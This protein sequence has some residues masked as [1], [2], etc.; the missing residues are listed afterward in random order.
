MDQI[1]ALVITALPEEFEAARLAAGDDVRWQEREAGSSAPYIRGELATAAGGSLAVALARP[2]AMSGRTT[3]PITT[4]LAA[5][6]RPACL[7]MCGVCAGNPADTAPGDVLVAAPAFQYDEGKLR[8]DE[9]LGDL[10]QLPLEDRWLR[11][12]QDFDP[13]GLPSQGPATADEAVVW[14]LERLLLGQEPR[15]HP[16][17]SRYFPR[18]TWAPRLADLEAA[19]LIARAENGTVVLTD[20]GR[21]RI[22]RVRY[23]TVDGPE[24]LP[25]AVFAG[26]MGSGNAVV[27]DPGVWDRLRHMGT[28]K[29]LGLEMEAATVATVAEHSEVPHWLVAKGVMDGAE[30]VRED[31]FKEF[32]A[33]SSAEVLFALLG[34]LLAPAPRSPSP[35]ELSDTTR[36]A[37]VRLEID[38]AV[39]GTVKIEVLQRLVYDWQDLAD[40]VGIPAYVRARF[41]RGD[42]PRGVWEWLEVRGRLGELPGALVRIGRDDLAELL[43]RAD[44]GPAR[45]PSS[46]SSSS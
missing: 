42:E 24:R 8:G 31:R 44:G 20:A 19:G 45:P 5:A 35:D 25:F 14:L 33:R 39:P 28:R 1:D 18:G 41:E 26:P 16:A 7:A 30:L 32:A 40:V 12:A 22:E 23:D 27:Q 9:F 34:R 10:R 2:P 38:M 15:V 43:P 4:T 37:R 11:A 46:S 3:A 13:T 6:L 36:P 21:G 17:R 29:I